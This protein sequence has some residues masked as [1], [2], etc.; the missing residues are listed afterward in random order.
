MTLEERISAWMDAHEAEFIRDTARLVAIP[1]VSGPAAPGA[2]FGAECRRALDE[3]AAL[4]R[5]YGFETQIYGGAM[6]SADYNGERA[7]LDIL[8]HLDVVGPGEGWDSDPF[9]ARA[10]G[11]FLFGRGVDD[12]K[13][14]FVLALF[15]M[16]CLKEL[17]IELRSG[18]RLLFG[19]HEEN[20]SD[21]LPY[22]YSNHA[23]AAH[24]FTPDTGFPVYNTE[25]GDWRIAVSRAW[26][27]GEALPRLESAEGGFR[28]NVVPGDASAR[29]AGLDARAVLAAAAPAAEEYGVGLSAEDVPG[30]CEL[31]V[32]GRQAHAAA[33]WL[34]NNAVTALIGILAR[35][36][37]EGPA[38]GALKSLARFFPHGDWLGEGC[39]V[40]MADGESGPLTLSANILGITPEGLRLDADARVPLSAT[41]ENC[42]GKL[43]PALAAAGFS[44][45]GV[46]ERAHHTPPDGGFI[47]SLLE[48]YERYTG[49]KGECRAT[50]AGTYVHNIPGGVG[51]GAYMPGFDTRLHGANERIRVRD[52]LTAGKIFALAIAKI[53]EIKED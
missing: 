28:I 25:K 14:P 9:A 35:L 27:R 4:C 6:G 50:G 24:T 53:C 5:G 45:G 7:A 8:A 47:R 11:G 21:D 16:R 44:A 43:Y 52:A 31:R 36:P 29:I 49:Q 23:P 26:P 30:G 48:S 46:M 33:P 40:A 2:P 19:T 17:G 18:C 10:E 32:H 41:E 13:G 51:F 38:A 12:D 1:S 34:G 20:G 22:Y 3:A 39:G 37:L 15:A 42:P